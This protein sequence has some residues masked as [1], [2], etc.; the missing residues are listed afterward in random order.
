MYLRHSLAIE[1]ANVANPAVLHSGSETESKL[2][3]GQ[4]LRERLRYGAIGA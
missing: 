4:R 2:E 3:A 1:E